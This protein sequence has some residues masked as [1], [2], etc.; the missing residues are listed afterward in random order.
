MRLVRKAA[1][2]NNGAVLAAVTFACVLASVPPLVAEEPDLA[3]SLPR[4][5]PTEAAD[6]LATFLLQPGFK[7]ELVAAEPLV[8]SP[9]EMQFDEDGLLW[10]IEMIDYPYDKREGVPPQ[11]RVKILEDTNQDGRPDCGF[12]FADNLGWPTSLAFW[13]GG[14]FVA[15]APHIYY[16][17]DTNG[18]H[19]ADVREI[20]FTGF[21]DSNVQALF[22]NLRWGPDHWIYGQNGGNGGNV[23][24]LRKP[25]L[26]A[27]PL[28][29]RDFRFRPT[30][31]LEAL[32]GGRGRFS[33]TF[34]D[35]GRRFACSTTHPVRHIVLEERLVRANPHLK[36]PA[37]VA[38]IAPEG[39]AGPV[40]PASPPEP[41]RVAR[42]KM[43]LAGDVPGT[44]ATLE[45]GSRATGY[46][47]GATGLTVYRG[48][49]LGDQYGTLFVGECAQNLIHRR[50]LVP[51]GSTFRAERV[52]ATSEFLVSSD[53]WFRPV[54]F[55]NGPD[56]AL[57]LCDMYREAIEHPWSIPEVIKKHLDLT[58]GKER[59]RLWRITGEDPPR[60]ERPRLGKADTASLVA[61]LESREGWWRDTALRLLYERQ[62]RAAVPLVEKLLRHDRPEVRVAALWALDGLGHLRGDALLADPHA[63]VREQAVR[64]AS[65]ERLFDVDDADPRVRLELASRMAQTDD[66]R[67]VEVLA[68]LAPGADSWL[69]TAIAAAA[70]GREAALYSH[71][72]RGTRSP[73]RW[74]SPLATRISSRRWPRR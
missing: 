73:I 23:R 58:S 62:V 37:L 67:A 49:A 59:G 31:E 5:A 18:D 65:I 46:F 68:R 66:P 64:L 54:N 21:G 26:P 50:A 40:Y 1:T 22:S 28:E 52:D 2:V 19:V 33:N 35:F 45:Q 60:R 15:A 44:V 20:V 25:D 34:D 30:G 57:Y 42:T 3:K 4:L 43:L 27:V 41:W 72:S 36:V 17:K 74:R 11:G 32:A 56:G 71:G 14:V 61:A 24:S 10:V 51:N 6:A 9:V 39:S 29:G 47:T 12:V 69:Q 70:R 7:I 38:L 63:G 53:N 55:A 8:A 13:D 16:L 48:T